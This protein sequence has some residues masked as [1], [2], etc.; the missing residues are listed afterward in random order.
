MGLSQTN[1]LQN[2]AVAIGSTP[3][4]ATQIANNDT[5]T[6]TFVTA[7]N[8]G[9]VANPSTTITVTGGPAASDSLQNQ[10]SELNAQLQS[11]NLDIT[12][13]LNSSG[14]LQFQS[15]NAFSVSGIAGTAA[16]LVGTAAE[17]A[18]NTGLSNLNVATAAVGGG[19]HQTIF[20]SR[21]AAPQSTSIL[22][23]TQPVRRWPIPS[24]RS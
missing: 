15:A 9:T 19:Q 12:A 17:T 23:R 4:V 6:F 24:I 8:T 20:R 21:S 3:I 18:N 13:S 1:V 22:G 16:N 2:A 7:G 14:Q 11:A 5:A 10:M